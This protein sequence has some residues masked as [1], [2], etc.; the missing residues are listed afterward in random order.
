MQ[1]TTARVGLLAAVGA[2]AVVLF[3]VLSNGDDN[4]D[5]EDS[6]N[7]TVTTGIETTAE[8]GARV[9]IVRDGQ[10][11]GG[12]QELTF[13]KGDQVN[14]E[15]RFDQPEEEVHVHGYEIEKPA[16]KSPVLISF[17]A[18]IDGVFEIEVHEEGGGEFEIAELRVNL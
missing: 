4:D 6:T 15:V 1:S 2:A 3:I 8:G 14:L 16:Q 9:L 11:V 18:S 17:P 13:N 10:P 12:V 5:G 7:S